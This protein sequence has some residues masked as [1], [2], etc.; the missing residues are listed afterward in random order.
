MTALLADP[1]RR[2]SLMA[3]VVSVVLSVLVFVAVPLRYVFGHPTMSKTVSP[4]HGALYLVLVGCVYLLGRSR[5]WSLPR[6]ALVA[7][8]GTVPILSFYAERRVSRETRREDASRPAE[9]LG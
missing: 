8:A 3:N 9:R 7:L 2:Y 1:L 4:I 6:T 5:G